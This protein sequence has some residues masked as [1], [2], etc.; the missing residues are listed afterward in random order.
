M[1]TGF[2]VPAQD[3]TTICASLTELRGPFCS[4][5][6]ALQCLQKVNGKRAAE[7]LTWLL[8]CMRRAAALGGTSAVQH[9]GTARSSSYCLQAGH[10][11]AGRCVQQSAAT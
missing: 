4:L 5:E 10:G 3:P 2:S 11:G 1:K 7:I 8:F 9:T 6:A